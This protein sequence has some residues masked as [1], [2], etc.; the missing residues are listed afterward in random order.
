[1]GNNY[2]AL[3]KYEEAERAYFDAWKMAPSRFYP[4]YLLYKLYDQTNQNEKAVDIARI[5]MNKEIKIGSTAI[6][7]IQSEM[8]MMIEKSKAI[9]VNKNKMQSYNNLNVIRK[10]IEEEAYCSEIQTDKFILQ[11]W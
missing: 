7:E 6:K 3:G 9:I 2:K 11:K 10:K 4:L 5:I 8:N 1:M